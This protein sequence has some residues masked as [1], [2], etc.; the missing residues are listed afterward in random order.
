[1]KNTHAHYV[2]VSGELLLRF[3]L[4]SRECLHQPRASV[5]SKSHGDTWRGKNKKNKATHPSQVLSSRQP[6]NR[7][8][9][10][11]MCLV[12]KD[13]S[14][15]LDLLRGHVLLLL[16]FPLNVVQQ[17]GRGAMKMI[18][19]KKFFRPVRSAKKGRC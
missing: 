12:L 4:I 2:S 19:K 11:F 5:M 16:L 13:L 18:K 3:K 8:S 6:V 7:D 1:M 15:V 14:D 9:S 17:L 10:G